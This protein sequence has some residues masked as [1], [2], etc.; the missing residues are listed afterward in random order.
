MDVQYVA[1][2]HGVAE[3]V[4]SYLC[5]AEI[6]GF[7]SVL[8]AE[9]SKLSYDAT[10]RRRLMR[11]GTLML[12]FRPLSAQ[13]AAYK[14]MGLKYYGCSRTFITIQTAPAHQRRRLLKT[15]TQLQQLP[16]GSTDIFSSNV[17]TRYQS[18]PAGSLWDD[19]SLATFASM[20]VKCK[21]ADR[22]SIE[23]ADNE[24]W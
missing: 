23:L 6:T 10:Q 19:M 13:E 22:N 2:V 9:L 7:D 5:K 15:A 24:T 18:R 16:D 12:S 11:I 4:C 1:S 17:I 3:Y 21:Q 20:Y 14:M 8:R